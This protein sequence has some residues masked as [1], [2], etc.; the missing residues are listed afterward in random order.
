MVAF[1]FRDAHTCEDV[2]AAHG[3]PFSRLVTLKQQSWVKENVPDT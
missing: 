2:G 1:S 3:W